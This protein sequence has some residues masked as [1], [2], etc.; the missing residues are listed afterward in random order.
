M[1]QKVLLKVT[2]FTQRY[3]D[4][5]VA[6]CSSLANYY[7][8]S[9]KYKDVRKLVPSSV[10]KHGMYSPEIGKFLNELSFSHVKIISADTEVFDFSWRNHRVKWKINRLKKLRNYYLRSSQHSYHD[11]E[12]IEHYIDF[13]ENPNCTNDLFIDYDFPKYIK[14][15]I[16]KG[17]PVVASI[18]YTSYFKM[19]KECKGQFDDIRGEPTD[20]AF[21]IRGFDPIYIYVVDSAG[22]RTSK[23]SGYYKI[24][25]EHFLVNIGSGDIIVVE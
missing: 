25:W 12:F 14:S 9:I 6:A 3:S 23:Y 15:S 19:P 13:L 24:K 5:A 4:C 21:I 2:R 11:I 8:P 16:R 17:H 20:H 18:N 7:T 1:R 22:R 10:L